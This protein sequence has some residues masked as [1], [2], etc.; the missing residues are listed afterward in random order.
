MVKYT[1]VADAV[2]APGGDRV[3]SGAGLWV[4]GGFADRVGLSGCLSEALPAGGE[5]APVHDRGA[6]LAH[7]CLVLA[8]GG[9]ACS[10]VERL[11][12][13]PELFGPVASPAT[14]WRAMH[15]ID[16]EA[17]ARVW[18]AAKQVRERVWAQAPADGPLVVGIDSTLVEARSDNKQGAAAHF[19]RGYGFHPMVCSTSEGEPLWG[20]LRPGNAAANSIADHIFVLDNAVSMLPERDAAGHRPG[21]DPGLARR[22]VLVRIDAAGCSKEIARACRDRN[23]GFAA[24]ARATQGIDAAIAAARF[25]HAMWAPAVPNPKHA[26]KPNRARVADLTGLADLTGWP[27]GTRLIVRREPRR[28]GAQRSLFPSE[29]YRYWGFLTDAEGSPAGVDQLMRQHARIESCIG[30]L[31]DSGLER[32]P[33]TSWQANSAWTAICLIALALVTWFQALR[34]QGALAKAAPKR[35][36]RQLWHLPAIIS[37]HA[38]RTLIRIPHRHHGATALLAAHHPR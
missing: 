17:L 6:L 19:K 26:R 27:E 30:R 32:M 20:M 9:E 7:L 13:E 34:L 14:L 22:P 10:D 37:R 28:P 36:R 21:D 35:L 25:D 1:S 4:L 3:V 11:R 24:S 2:L 38:R 5:R 16:D 8:G 12:G 29:H 31:K 33:F 23:I 15:E 18:R